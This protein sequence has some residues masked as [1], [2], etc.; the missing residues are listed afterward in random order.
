MPLPRSLVNIRLEVSEK[1]WFEAWN[2]S[3]E[4]VNGRKYKMPKS[5]APK[6]SGDPEIKATGR[7]VPTISER[8]TAA[9]GCT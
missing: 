7:A 6:R 3:K 1:K 2:W 9:P 5:Q 4:R 8:G